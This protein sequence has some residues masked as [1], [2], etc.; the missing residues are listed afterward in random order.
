MKN[1]ATGRLLKIVVF[2]MRRFEGMMLW[3]P[4]RGLSRLSIN[5]R[6]PHNSLEISPE[7]GWAIKPDS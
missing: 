2:R 4:G 7:E 6:K 1:A 5:D 3:L